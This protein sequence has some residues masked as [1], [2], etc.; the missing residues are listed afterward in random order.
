MV[1]AML[2]Q[3]QFS[4]EISL[5]K[6]ILKTSAVQHFD[7]VKFYQENWDNYDYDVESINYRWFS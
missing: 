1:E 3:N 4:L 7:Q 5:S 2:D 6:A